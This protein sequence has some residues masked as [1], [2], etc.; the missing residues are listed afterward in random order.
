MV[1]S[2]CLSV[3]ILFPSEEM[4][5]LSKAKSKKHFQA[6]SLSEFGVLLLKTSI[7]SHFSQSELA[8]AYP[9]SCWGLIT[10]AG[11][12]WWAT[13]NLVPAAQD[14]HRHHSPPY[15]PWLTSTLS[16]DARL[17][18][19]VLRLSSICPALRRALPSDQVRVMNAAQETF[20][21]QHHLWHLSSNTQLL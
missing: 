17:N 6:W 5:A 11:S 15:N 9:P 16:E 4:L 10:S 20:T 8:E 18:N 7:I 19:L 3:S 1:L 14:S 21:S 2:L 13:G 12:A